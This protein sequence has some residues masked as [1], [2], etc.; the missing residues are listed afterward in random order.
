MSSIN[1]DKSRF[2]RVRKQRIFQRQRNRVLVHG[3]MSASTT[4]KTE[5]PLSAPPAA[6]TGTHRP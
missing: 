2:N 1:G 6:K 4:E 5:V 3:L